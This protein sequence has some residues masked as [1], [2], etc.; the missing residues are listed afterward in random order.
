[1]LCSYGCSKEA[2]YQLKNGKWCCSK[3]YKKCTQ[4][5]LRCKIRVSGTGNP[6]YG[7]SKEKNPFFGK[8]HTTESKLKMSVNN[9]AKRDN[10]KE[11]MSKSAT[12]RLLKESTKEKL[13]Q[14]SKN[15]FLDEK[16][17]KNYQNGCHKKP[18]NTEKILI[19]ILSPLDYEFVGDYKKWIGGKNPDFINERKKKIIEFFGWRHTEKATGIPNKIHEQNRID[20]FQKFGYKTL[21]L[22][23]NDLKDRTKLFERI[24]TFT[25]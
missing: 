3:H 23:D 16:Y 13:R 1:M 20:H 9:A 21:V 5:R 24:I 15:L 4:E 25:K 14:I 18:N 7:K 22:W 10:I 19:T 17:L 11:K 12:G 8:K 6:M 2:L